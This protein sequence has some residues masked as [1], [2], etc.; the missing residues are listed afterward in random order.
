MTLLP[1][2]MPITTKASYALCDVDVSS[3]FLSL[4]TDSGDTKEDV[5]LGRAEDG[6]EFDSV[7]Q[8]I[9]QRFEAGEAL[10]VTVLSIMGKDI[11]DGVTKD[12]EG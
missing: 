6:K 11:V 8:E 2:T 5:K 7:G 9:V 3:G 12:T 1:P 4:L 10:K